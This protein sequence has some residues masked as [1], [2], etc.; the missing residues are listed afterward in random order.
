MNLEK[1]LF[2]NVLTE[3]LTPPSES[4]CSDDD[5]DFEVALEMLMEVSNEKIPRNSII[6]YFEKMILLNYCDAEFERHFRI[7]RNLFWDITE[8]FAKSNIYKRVYKFNPTTTILPE[9]TIAIFLYFAAHESYC[10]RS[11]SDR[12]N[13]SLST[14][15]NSVLRGTAFFSNL[16]KKFIKWPTTD[17]MRTE[18][19]TREIESGIPGIIGRLNYFCVQ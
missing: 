18:A 19:L 5:D 10:F 7:D 4:E 16:S 11:R 13:I 12:F 14:V 9:K 2:L 8:E 17:E 15:H 1:E 6:D 3:N